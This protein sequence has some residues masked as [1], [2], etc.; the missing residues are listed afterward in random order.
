M[1]EGGEKGEKIFFFFGEQLGNGAALGTDDGEIGLGGPEE[2]FEEALAIEELAGFD[3][4]H[5]ARDA[6]NDLFP[7]GLGLVKPETVFGEEEG[8]DFADIAE[9]LGG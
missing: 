5:P 6:I 3:F 8:L 7:T 2:A 9:I 4:E 1:A